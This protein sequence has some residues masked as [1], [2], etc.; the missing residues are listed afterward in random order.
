MRSFIAP[1]MRIT[2][3]PLSHRL[4]CVRL[5]MLHLQKPRRVVCGYAVLC[6]VRCCG[7]RVSQERI[8]VPAVPMDP[9]IFFQP[10]SS[11][12]AYHGFS[13]RCKQWD[14]WCHEQDQQCNWCSEQDTQLVEKPEAPQKRWQDTQQVEEQETPLDGGSQRPP[15]SRWCRV[16]TT[17]P[18]GF[19]WKTGRRWTVHRIALKRLAGNEFPFAQ[20]GSKDCCWQRGADFLDHPAGEYG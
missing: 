8:N 10:L 5:Y 19:Q 18:D 4:L 9:R 17:L 12:L 16:A 13:E 7:C 20:Q 1:P 2:S 6:Y 14:S 3:Y 15:H 11:H